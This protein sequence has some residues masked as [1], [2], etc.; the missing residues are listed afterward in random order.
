MPWVERIKQDGERRAKSPPAPGTATQQNPTTNKKPQTPGKGKKQGGGKAR[1]AYGDLSDEDF[2][3]TWRRGR[4]SFLGEHP[5]KD[6][7]W[8][9]FRADFDSDKE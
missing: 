4:H 9:L 8:S 2:G 1:K 7:V 5:D 3:V 6:S